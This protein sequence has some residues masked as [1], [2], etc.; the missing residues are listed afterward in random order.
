MKVYNIK[1][2]LLLFIFNSLNLY[3]AK[4]YVSITGSND[5]E[6]TIEQPLATITEAL[7]HAREIRQ[8]NAN[9]EPIE[10]IIQ[11]GAYYLK[12]PL[13]LNPDDSGTESSPLIIK[14]EFGSVPILSGG[15]ELAKFEKVNDKLWKI[16]VSETEFFEGTIPQLYVNG[17]RAIKARTPNKGLLFRTKGASENKIDSTNNTN[18]RIAVQKIDLS[19]EQVNVLNSIP[20]NNI[21]EVIINIHHAWDRTRKYIWSFN[22][23]DSSLFINGR[24]MHFYNTLDNTSQLY[25]ENSM[26]FLDSPGEWFQGEGGVIYYIPKEGEKIETSTATV[27]ITKQ[28][29]IIEGK[30]KNKVKHVT[31]E[32]LS[33]KYSSYHMPRLGNEPSQAAAATDA[34][35]MVDYSENIKFINC[36]IAHTGTSAI[37][38]RSGNENCS[39]TDSYLH[40]LG[41]GGV[42]I[43]ETRSPKENEFFTRNI[44]IDNNIIRSG[45]HE[46]PTGVGIIIFHSSDNIVTHNEIADFGYTGISVGWVWGYGKSVAARNNISY[47]HIH[48][49][50]WGELSDMGGIYTLGPSEGTIINN[51]HIHHIYSYGYGG[52]GIY[53]DEGS[54]GIKIE[55]NLVYKCKSSGFHQH[56]GKDNIIR[57][58][59]FA[60]Q[61]KGQL[62]ASRKEDHKSFL[63]TNNIIYFDN[64]D[65]IGQHGWKHV[66][67]DSDY[68]CY[69]DTRTTHIDFEG[70][71]FNEFVKT[72]GN[73]KN[74]II[75]DPGFVNPLEFNFQIMNN[76]V[77]DKINFKPFDYSLSGVYGDSDWI[78]LAEFSKT[79]HLEFE[80]MV[81]KR[82]QEKEPKKK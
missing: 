65:L 43:G 37:W 11:G 62:E 67:F 80:K 41:V 44:T 45:S 72:T 12:A 54:T 19:S 18:A 46:F 57:N 75:A 76:S 48:H 73:D 22:P 26:E 34:A 36:E 74:S 49:I 42:K 38:F 23:S 50:G 6:G 35:I 55:N 21:N 28:L 24:E 56:Y 61:Y 27:P 66:N 7:K 53:T 14:G 52:W 39:L 32:N 33:F 69:W 31:F 79:R 64:G 40:D 68:N 10:I 81:D 60:N 59:I 30:N 29:V 58:N 15:M 51:N 25:F 5:N 9:K 70:L 63:F 47:N 17:E 71:S 16:H 3:P 8:S 82:L 77:I 1:I 13:I 78:K 20:K 2:L 4:I